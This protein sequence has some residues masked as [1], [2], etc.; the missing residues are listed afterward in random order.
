MAN[1]NELTFSENQSE[2]SQMK[3]FRVKQFT[4]FEFKNLKNNCDSKSEISL[5]QVQVEML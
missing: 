5:F 1:P 3:C 2:A 4:E